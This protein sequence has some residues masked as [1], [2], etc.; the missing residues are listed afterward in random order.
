MR[1]EATRIVADG[2]QFA[3]T[4]PCQW[5]ERETR[6]H[7]PVASRD[8][9]PFSRTSSEG[10]NWSG[11]MGRR[12][13]SENSSWMQLNHDVSRPRGDRFCGQNLNQFVSSPSRRC[14]SLSLSEMRA[15][16]GIH[17][18]RGAVNFQRAVV[19]VYIVSYSRFTVGEMR[20]T[21]RRVSRG[22]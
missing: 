20:R 4:V 16:S 1:H 14:P 19:T 7:P 15:R 21:K 5:G 13:G 18:Y 8:H 17:S 3:E 11:G 9:R 2:F 6:Q 12:G 22:G 10:N